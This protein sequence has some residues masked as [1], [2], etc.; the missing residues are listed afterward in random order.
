METLGMENFL[1]LGLNREQ[2]QPAEQLKAI[3]PRSL[4]PHEH[5]FFEKIRKTMKR[6]TLK[7]KPKPRALL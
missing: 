4:V 3:Q 2:N 1:L 6:D 7:M 5:S